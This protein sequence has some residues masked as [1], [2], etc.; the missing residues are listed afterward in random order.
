[1]KPMKQVESGRP[2]AAFG[3]VAQLHS[4]VGGRVT[5]RNVYR[6]EC[7]APVAVSD[8]EKLAHLVGR[9]GIALPALWL[10][11]H[12]SHKWLTRSLQPR[13]TIIDP[14][15]R[16]EIESLLSGGG[17]RWTDGFTNRVVNVG[18]DEYLDKVWKASGYTAAHYVGLTDSTPTDAAGDTMSS[19]AGWAEV[20]AYSEST[21]PALT[22]G[23]VSSQSVNNTGNE[24]DFTASGSAT[25][26][27]AFITTNNTKGGTTGTLMTVGAFSG[28]DKSLTT[29]DTLSVGV[30]LTLA[31]A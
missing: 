18:L 19:H 16:R 11:G 20:T 2:G 5:P 27:G 8:V 15:A 24:A 14:A 17:L 26:G 23:T 25:V 12:V 29:S 3:S 30:T 7:H 1:M 9:L 10:P 13:L 4:H 31:D 21:R 28:G 6:V 22:L